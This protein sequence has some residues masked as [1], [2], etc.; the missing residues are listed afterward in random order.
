[1]YC[2]F[3]VQN[4]LKYVIVPIS[5]SLIQNVRQFS[6]IY[7]YWNKAN[8]CDAAIFCHCLECINCNS[9]PWV[10][11]IIPIPAIGM[12]QFSLRSIKDYAICTLFIRLNILYQDLYNLLLF[13]LLAAWCIVQKLIYLKS[14]LINKHLHSFL[15]ILLQ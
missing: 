14:Y 10:I 2:T 3:S 9:Y 8:Q 6:F 5:T 1:M 4:S 15:H 12:L 7:L 11:Q 13:F